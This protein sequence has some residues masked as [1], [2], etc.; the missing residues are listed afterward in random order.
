MLNVRRAIKE[1]AEQLEPLAGDP[2]PLAIVLANPNQVVA[3]ITGD[4][5]IEAIEGDLAV[6]FDV[7]TDT[8]AKVSEHRWVYGE[9]GCFAEGQAP[10]VSAV[11]G[12]HRGDLRLDW[13][14]EYMERWKA[15]NWPQEPKSY[16]D[17]VARWEAARTAL[18]EALKTE[19]APSGDYY[20]LHVVETR[21]EDAVPLPRNI[22]DAERDS[23][24]VANRETGTYELVSGPGNPKI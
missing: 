14:L 22:L 18:R 7:S 6:T 19:D 4:K 9:G 3:E 17:G 12:V 16:D 20:Y 13:E 24:W 11:V 15:E 5:L 10:W 1:A 21:N 8:G 2:R 23:R